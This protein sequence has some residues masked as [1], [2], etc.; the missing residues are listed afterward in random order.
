M[1]GNFNEKKFW[2]NIKVLEPKILE[3]KVAGKTRLEIA[4]Q[5]GLN[6]IQ[7]KT[8]FMT[9]TEQ[10]VNIVLNTIKLAMVKE[11]AAGLGGASPQRPGGINTHHRYFNLTKD[12]CITLF[13]LRRG[14]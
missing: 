4:D 6:K 14:T 5:L 9:R 1:G 3:M 11:N 8:E 10:T 13:M 12:Y 2:T 7:I